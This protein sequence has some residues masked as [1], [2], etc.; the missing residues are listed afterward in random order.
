MC[1]IAGVVA[2]DPEERIDSTRVVRMRDSME[3]RGPDGAGLWVEGPVGLGHRRLAIVDVGGGHQPM[4]NEDDSVW[5]VF[6]GEIYN[7]NDLRP[8][9][10]E[11]G[12]V[13][14][15]RCDTETILHAYDEWGDDGLARLEGMFA[16]ALW[17]RRAR[18]LILGRDRLGIKPLY[19]AETDQELLFASEV[20]ALVAGGVR[21]VL[22]TAALP[23]YLA[24]R[25]VTGDATS[26]DAVRRV[27]PGHLMTWSAGQKLTSRCYWR[28]SARQTRPDLPMTE[29]AETVGVG[30]NAA[31]ER[32]LMSDVPLGVFLSGGLDS[33]ALAAIASR[34]V[35]GQLSTFSVGFDEPEGN[36]LPY[37]RQVAQAIRS[38]HR[39]VVVSGDEFF[40]ALPHLIWHQDEPMAFSSG[41]PLYFVSQLARSDV[42]VV[43]TGEGADELFLGYN[44]YR[45]TYWNERLGLPYRRL[46]AAARAAVSAGLGRLPRA[47]RR[48]TDR[49]FLAVGAG[50]RAYFENFAVFQSA[51]SSA[52]LS[53]AIRERADPFGFSERCYGEASG[54]LLDRL[55]ATDLRTYLGE[56]LMKQDRMSMAASIESRVPFLDDRLV[57][58]VTGMPASVKLRGW[59][60]KAVLREAVANLIPK[61]ILQRRK[62]GFPVPLARW[63]RGRH[64][65]VVD[66]FVAGPRAVAR[67]LFRPDAL[68]RL[69]SE[70][71]RGEA[72]HAERLWLLVNL[73]MWQRIFCDGEAPGDV[74][75]PLTRRSGRSYA[76]GL[77][78]SWR[79]VASEHRR[80]AADV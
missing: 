8:A 18:R 45:V 62:M 26:F 80:T 6:N 59:Q 19:I 31:V 40:E 10:I 56:L 16:F 72:N 37:A 75:R 53:P 17:D 76:G 68:A 48:Y 47:F 30:L 58:T 11:R 73:E 2:F 33:S 57:A 15:T 32:H 25:Y 67:G 23:E 7:H 61:A 79:F 55:G 77:D 65:A 42:K 43:L 49:T 39:D 46:P 38:R 12:H 51:Q 66:E 24:H 3:H 14:R 44:R 9:L 52:L 35:E 74:T 36:E 27:P 4:A 71:A 29:A 63:F 70:H 60:T 20:K 69:A 64:R 1:G 22:N 28:L 54:D 41:V 78:Q 5:V 50:T 21:P 13:Y 34:M